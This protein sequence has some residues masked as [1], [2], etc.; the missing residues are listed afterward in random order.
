MNIKKKGDSGPLKA[1]VL[2]TAGNFTLV[3]NINCVL[4]KFIVSRKMRHHVTH[5]NEMIMQ[6]LF[7][8]NGRKRNT[9]SSIIFIGEYKDD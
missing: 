9:L 3:F 8:K 6:R 7:L 2:V 1:N 5:G 4:D